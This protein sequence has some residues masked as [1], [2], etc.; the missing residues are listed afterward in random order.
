M[1]NH[2]FSGYF[3]HGGHC[4]GIAVDKKN[5][6]IYYSFTT[7]LV[8]SDLDGNVIGS[9][10]KIVG[11]LGCIDFNEKD[12]K[13][14]ASLEYKNDEIGRGILKSI[15]VSDESLQDAFYIAI[16]DVDKIDRMDMDAENDGIMRTVYLKAVVDDYNGTA[17]NGK[18]HVYG[19]SG[20]DGMT[21]GP[22]F[23]DFKG[24]K[25]YLSVCE[26]I[27]S[28]HSRTDNDYQVMYQYDTDGWWDNLAKPL[29]Q[30]AMHKSGPD[31]PRRK[32]FFY[33]GNTTYGVQNFEYDEFTG[34]YFACVYTGTK[35]QFPNYP[36]FVV[37]GSKEAV[38]SELVGHDNGERG[39]V[40][41]LKDTGKCEN[42]VY[43]MTFPH[44]STGLYSFGDGR[45]F[46]SHH[47]YSEEQG[48]ATNVHLYRL[49]KENGVL[50]FIKEEQN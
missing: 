44:G 2:I 30:R 12:G 39:L 33:T 25:Y 10:D 36:M 16:F 4:Q 37:D 41:S 24:E 45:F 11:H 8:K 50:D 13:L 40:L 32:Y 7:K 42:G 22:D 38:E 46:V 18:M 49:T 14:Y 35:P 43:G 48:H 6:Y 5:G 34:D 15:G 9:I 3:G 1:K 31:E 20:I 21:F 29:N 23:G 17:Q 47:T 27:Y 28:D 26:G 19:C